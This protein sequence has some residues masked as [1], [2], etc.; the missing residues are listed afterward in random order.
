MIGELG[1]GDSVSTNG[2]EL[3]YFKVANGKRCAVFGV[4]EEV[5]I[6]TPGGWGERLIENG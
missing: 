2:G 5:V 4:C 1:E 3:P 6:I